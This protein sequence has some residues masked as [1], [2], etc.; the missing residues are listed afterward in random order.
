VK[1]L[2]TNR[3]PRQRVVITGIGMLASVGGDRESVWR[4]VRQGESG[5]RLIKGVKAI[6]DGLLIA[7]QVDVDA[8]R[9]GRLK[10]INLCMPAAAEAVADSQLDLSECDPQRCGAAISGH[11]G[12]TD[13]VVE[14][15]NRW[16]MIDPGKPPWW[17]QWYPCSACSFVANH[18]RLYGPR[19]SHSTA[20]S[21]G[22]I[23]ILAATRAIRDGRCD[24]ALVGSAEAIHPL[25]AAGFHRMGVLAY[26]A[27]DPA[28]ACRPF[29]RN[30]SGFVMGEGAAMFIFER[31]DLAQQRGAKIYAEILGGHILASAYHVT[32]LDA[33]SDALV[34]LIRITLQRAGLPTQA[35]DYINAH[36]TGTQQNDVME[37]RSIRRAFGAAADRIC[38]SATK[39][40]LGHLVNASGSVELA[41]TALA[42]RD[43]FLPPTRNLTDPDPQCQ[44]DC[45]PNI[46]RRVA[47]EYAIK[48]SIAFGGH[49]A[50]VAIRRWPEGQSGRPPEPVPPG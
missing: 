13:F 34:E 41:V 28:G 2:A 47:A 1:T 43:G 7:A 38:V 4:A 9:P 3:D 35:I 21:S 46:G 24:R 23:D 20:C 15:L 33:D 10:P 5:V 26:D 12:D 36:G 45:L 25:F 22:L 11:M 39:S 8:D 49:L 19:I 6:P 30:R 27:D 17:G 32:G 37:A 31:L 18:Y 44:I 40:M 50:A 14:Q 29:D 42:L 48:L 16:D